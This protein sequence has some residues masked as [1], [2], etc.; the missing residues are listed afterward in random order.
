[1]DYVMRHKKVA[2]PCVRIKAGAAGGSG[3]ILYNKENGDGEYS[4]YVLTNHHVVDGCIEI[5]KKWSP[6]LKSERK[7]D[8]FESVDV[9]LFEYR[10]ESRDIGGTTIQ[11]DIMTYD[12]DEDLALLKLRTNF[13]MQSVAALYPRGKEKELRIGMP[14]VCVGAGLGE[15]PVQTVGILSQ[16]GREIDR[17]EY[18]ISTAPAIYG[19][20]GGALFLADTYEMIGV[21]ARIAVTL[22]MFG[23]DAIPHLQYAIPITRI[24]DF[25]EEQRFRF[26]YDENYTEEGEEKERQRL[27]EDEERK[28]AMASSS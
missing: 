16:F 23:S 14:V 20:S 9:H 5:K 2:L 3:T 26:I 18:W 7:T 8:V 21:P 22:T 12:P 24:Y 6:L 25:L 27:R 19:N 1:M 28:M 15:S 17:R 11:S 10:W 4:T 13:P